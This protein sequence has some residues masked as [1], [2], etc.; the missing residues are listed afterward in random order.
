MLASGDS[1]GS[2][3]TRLG[4]SD[5]QR[6]VELAAAADIQKKVQ[7][8]LDSVLGP[9]KSVVQASVAMDWTERKTTTESF[10]PDP[11]AVRSSQKVN[12]QYT[13]AGG[14][15]GG[16]P[17]AGSNLPTPVPT[18]AGTSGDLIYQRSEETINYELS[19][20]STDAV[21]NPGQL[22]RVSLSVMVD[23]ITDQD[24][25]DSL[26]SAVAA[27]AGI[28]QTRGDTLAVESLAFD[29]TYYE[30]QTAELQK[31]TQTDLYIK[32]GEIAAMVLV[33]LGLLWYV[34]RLF[35]NLKL[36]TGEAWT[37]I[38]KPVAE[39]ALPG[40]MGS[41]QM[42]AGSIPLPLG[43]TDY[44][45]PN[46]VVEQLAAVMPGAAAAA[47]AANAEDEQMV[48]VIS[49]LAEENPANVAE[50]IQLWLSEDEK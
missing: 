1:T 35:R 43:A 50:I 27:A 31:D 17:G 39:M 10:K 14:L 19:K 40:G 5:S 42:A 7:T 26:T 36:A 12:E 32:I 34:S 13:T 18:V 8:L 16:I 6:A 9:N 20:T 23:G 24:Q 41:A 44:G 46:G 47:Q 29:R 21:E 28:D 37:P 49:R 33:T 11:T 4:Q 45:A 2:M 25:L 48:K 38:L 30:T 15:V 3:E 22:K